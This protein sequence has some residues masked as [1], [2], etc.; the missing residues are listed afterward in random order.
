VYR[1]REQIYRRSSRATYYYHDVRRNLVRRLTT[2]SEKQMIPI[3]S[4]NSRMLAYVADNNIW[5]ARFDFDTESQITT[6]GKANHILN[7]ITD[8]VYEEDFSVT[9]LMEFSPDNR[10]L[11]F[12]RTDESAVR[13]FSFQLFNEQLY[14]TL[15][16]MRYPKAGETNS[17]VEVRVFD[18]EA[19]TTRRMDV[20]LDADGYIPRI[21]FTND[22]ERL[23]VMTLNRDQNRFD[24]YF[25]NPR[26]TVARLILREESRH[27]IDYRW[28]NSI[29]FFNDRFTYI[30]ERS[31]FSQLYIYGMTG[32]R[33]RQLTT[34]D[35]D[36]TAILAIDPQSNTVFFEAADESPMTRSVFRVNVDRGEPQRIS[37]QSGFNTASFSEHGRFFVNRW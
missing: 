25:V 19:R 36:V 11:A 33:Q 20:P 15:Y 13:E 24:M 32:T 35:F 12:V 7:G 23:A 16:T 27:F 22:P 26:T 37:Q 18:I 34:G 17:S 31:G 28:L 6:D 2:N 1:N 29:H 5:L 8:W 10:V 4:P 9:R 30:S 21:A 14:P 3:F